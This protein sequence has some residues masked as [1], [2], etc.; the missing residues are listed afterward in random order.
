MSRRARF[1]RLRGGA[2]AGAAFVVRRRPPG[3]LPPDPPAPERP[4]SA[5]GVPLA[6]R[7][8]SIAD[9]ARVKSSGISRPCPARCRPWLQSRA[10]CVSGAP[11]GTA[12]RSPPGGALPSCRLRLAVFFCVR[13]SAVGGR[14]CGARSASPLPPRLRF[15]RASR[16]LG[17]VALFPALFFSLARCLCFLCCS[18]RLPG[19]RVPLPRTLFQALLLPNPSGRCRAVNK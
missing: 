16:A 8:A 4:P 5:P 18:I 10:P 1:D 19:C 12:M 11:P 9:A 17:R 14:V 6:V 13:L 3:S 15:R 2:A 7:A